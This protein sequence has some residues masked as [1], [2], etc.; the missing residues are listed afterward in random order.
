MMNRLFLPVATVDD[1]FEEI[2]SAHMRYCIINGRDVFD[3]Q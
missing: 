3:L 2:P 1:K